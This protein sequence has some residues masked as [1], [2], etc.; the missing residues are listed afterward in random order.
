MTLRYMCT[1]IE[2]VILLSGSVSLV[3]HG[4]RHTKAYSSGSSSSER[5]KHWTQANT[6]V[7][8]FCTSGFDIYILS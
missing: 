4:V 5:M 3:M 2:G 7:H 6:K 8:L 1:V